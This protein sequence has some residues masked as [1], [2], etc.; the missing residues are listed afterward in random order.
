[1]QYICVTLHSTA[2]DPVASTTAT[3]FFF[4]PTPQLTAK[5]AG[6]SNRRG[7]LVSYGGERV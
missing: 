1:M 3:G 2:I 5:S 6:L 7:S 4:S